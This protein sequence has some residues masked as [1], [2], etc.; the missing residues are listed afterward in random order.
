M[1][2]ATKE[3]EKT[4]ED[5]DPKKA[6]NFSEESA[7]FIGQKVAV[8]CARYQYRGELSKV[9]ADCIVLANATAVEV[10]G[11]SNAETPQTEDNIGGSVIIKNDA[12]EILYQ[13]NWAQAELPAQEGEE[14]EA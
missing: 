13:P 1:S 10:S 8:L 9:N 11:P 3:T 5:F 7:Q 14:E 6:A 2:T 12:I 4:F